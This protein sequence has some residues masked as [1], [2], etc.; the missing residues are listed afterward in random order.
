MLKNLL[1]MS[2]ASVTACALVSF[3]PLLDHRAQAAE[4]WQEALGSGPGQIV[5]TMWEMGRPAL[6][7]ENDPIYPASSTHPLPGWFPFKSLVSDPPLLLQLSEDRK[8]CLLWEVEIHGKKDWAPR[9]GRLRSKSHGKSLS[10]WDSG[11]NGAAS[12]TVEFPVLG[13]EGATLACHC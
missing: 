1:S 11:A 8:I 7:L 9:K 13:V 2:A 10:A 5:L 12:G 4:A 3:C 6:P